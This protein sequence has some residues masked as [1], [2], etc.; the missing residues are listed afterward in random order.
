MIGCTHALA[1]EVARGE[2][3]IH[4]LPAQAR[5][6]DGSWSFRLAGGRWT[7]LRIRAVSPRNVAVYQHQ[8]AWYEDGSAIL[9]W[10]GGALTVEPARTYRKAIALRL[11]RR[12]STTGR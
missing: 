2:A 11:E 10:P 1:Q 8:T 5:C 4:H 12:S 7:R 9:H 3:L 6:I